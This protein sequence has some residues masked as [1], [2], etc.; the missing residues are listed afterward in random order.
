MG[1]GGVMGSSTYGAPGG[2]SRDSG[3]GSAMGG[4]ALEIGSGRDRLRPE[5]AE[6][7]EVE[8]AFNKVYSKMRGRLLLSHLVGPPMRDAA[9]ALFKFRIE[10]VT[11]RT[12]GRVV[13]AFGITPEEGCLF[14]LVNRL[15]EVIGDDSATGASERALARQCIEDF[16][17]AALGNDLDTLMSGTADEVLRKLDLA[18]F[19]DVLTK[20]LTSGLEQLPAKSSVRLPPGAKRLL[21]AVAADRAIKLC[22]QFRSRYVGKAHGQ[23]PQVG[24]SHMLDVLQDAKPQQ[25]FRK[26][27]ARS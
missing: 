8:E 16:F 19:D 23:I 18:A 11:N 5:V 1:I 13:E 22:D 14:R 26:A 3:V 12:W 21:H 7:V 27:V 20:L 4:F 15:G 6:R 2:L 25:W 9:A 17:V 10:V 24:M